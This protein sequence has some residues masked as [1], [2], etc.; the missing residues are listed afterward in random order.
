MSKHKTIVISA[1]NINEGGTLTV[2]RDCVNAASQTLPDWRI[3][4]L[5]HDK[6]LIATP[7]VELMEF[8]SIKRRWVRRVWAEWFQF[9]EL[10]QELNA[11]L[12]L[13][14]HDMTPRVIARR[15]AVYCHNPSPFSTPTLRDA[16]FGLS[17]FAFAMGYGLLYRAFLKRNHTVIVQQEWLRQRFRQ[18]YRATHVVVAHPDTPVAAGEIN[19]PSQKAGPPVFF[20]PALPRCFKNFEVIGEALGILAQNPEWRG[21][22]KWTLDGSENRYAA[23][24]KRR[25]GKLPGLQ[26]VGRQSRDGMAK[27]YSETDCLIFPSRVETWGL[28]IT[29]AKA[30]GLPILAAD[31]GY[32]HETVGNCSAADF[33]DPHNPQQLADKML[34]FSLGKPTTKITRVPEPAQPFVQSWP[35]LL[36]LLVRGL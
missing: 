8:P 5:V 14:L 33:F 28:P 32:A 16:W 3:I 9:K 27:Q 20:F 12:W 21:T 31:L 6:S 24:L 4:A 11:D 13:S 34:A 10:S 23:W 1:V 18:H 30:R 22:V 15:Q 26:W 29:E 2:L 36:R 17:Y 7:D 19:M 35:D 25:F